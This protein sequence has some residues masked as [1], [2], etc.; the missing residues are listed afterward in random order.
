MR[1]VD[2]VAER[3]AGVAA[4]HER[5]GLGHERAHVPDGAVHDD[6]DALHRDPA[7]GRGVAA[8]DDQPAAA[9]RRA[10][11]SR[12]AVDHDAAG[13]D[14]LRQPDAGVAVHAHRRALVHPGA[15]V[16]DVP[17]DVDLDLGVDPD[18]DRVRA[19]GMGDAPARRDAG[20]V[21]PAVEL[22]QRRLRQVDLLRGI[23]DRRHQTRSR[24][25][26]YTW[27]ARL[28]HLGRVGAGQHGDRAVLRRHRHPVVAL[29]HHRG[30]AGD[31]VAQHREPV[32]GPDG[33]RVEAVEVDQ[34]GLQRRLQRVALAQPPLQIPRRDLRVVLGLERDPL[35]A[36][37]APQAVVVR[38]RAV[39]HEAQVEAGRERMRALRG[40]LALG[41]HARVAEAV[42]AGHRGEV[43]A[44]HEPARVARLLED[45]DPRA[46]AHHAQVRV[47]CAHLRDDIARLAV[48]HDD[49]VT[50][51]HGDVGAEHA[52]VLVGVIGE[53][54]Q[55]RRP[56][57]ADRG[58]RRSP[59]SPGRGRPSGPAW[60]P[61]ARRGA[62]RLRGT[63]R[64]GRRFR[65]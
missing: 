40:H 53:Q 41:R 46:G 51:V 22:A 31:R 14:V 58:R 36:Q 56:R 16:A 33:E 7:A 57:R 39:V 20:G 62:P 15:V 2:R 59:R 38:Q 3:L 47:A 30:F 54:R 13:H 61:A 48:E 50:G 19:V 26:E 5:A 60:R 35:V 29:G 28:P 9:G 21:Q 23:G 1:L 18:G 55:L 44:L 42:G 4:H 34:A 10:G 52:P 63:S 6:L 64:T 45:L 27:P 17:V 43:E 12:I 32:R 24:S 25:H 65:T 11:L 49:R 8:H 37:H